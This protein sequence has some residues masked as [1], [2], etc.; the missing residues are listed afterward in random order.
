M[1]S[2]RQAIHSQQLCQ[3]LGIDLI[4]LFLAIGDELYPVGINKVT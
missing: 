2:L 3:D 1:N 4:R